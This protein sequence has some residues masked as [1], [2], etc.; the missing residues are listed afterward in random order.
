MCH[1]IF[2][3]TAAVYGNPERVPVRE[4]DPTIPLSPYGRS[5]LMTEPMLED[6]GSAHGPRYVIMRYFN[7]A[8]P[9]PW[10]AAVNQQ[11]ALLI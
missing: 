6:T 10:V 9:I 1:F 4:E 8:A 2:S 11:K 3:L 7:V 5:K